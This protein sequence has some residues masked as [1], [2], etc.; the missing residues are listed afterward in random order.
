MPVKILIIH[1][2]NNTPEVFRP[3]K[4]ALEEKGH[5]CQLITLPGHGERDLTLNLKTASELFHEEINPYVNEKYAVIAFSY[6]AQYFQKWLRDNRGPKPVA[7]VL[8]APAV[9]IRRF[10]ILN[11]IA[12][13]LPGQL[14]LPSQ[15]PKLLRRYSSLYVSEYKIL[16]EGAMEYKSNERVKDIP[17]LVMV[18]PKDELIDTKLLEVEFGE[19]LKF[20]SRPYLRNRKPGKYHVLFHPDYFE[21]NDWEKFIESI[22]NFL[23]K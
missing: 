18:D 14:C 1:G 9:V 7:Q 4:N 23:K 13:C 15:T 19:E 20:I 5:E 8:L 10:P 22:H 3:L 11:A 21:K 12:R 17:T 6:G 16:L 2:F